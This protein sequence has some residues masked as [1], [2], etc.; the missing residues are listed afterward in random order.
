L[1]ALRV[2]VTLV[3]FVIDADPLVVEIIRQEWDSE[4]P[5]GSEEAIPLSETSKVVEVGVPNAC[6]E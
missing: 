3:G 2:G 5:S 1:L 4:P 6:T